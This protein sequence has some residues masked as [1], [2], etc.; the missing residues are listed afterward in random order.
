MGGGL[1]SL[2]AGNAIAGG[3]CVLRAARTRIEKY[4]ERERTIWKMCVA[5]VAA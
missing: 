5:A 1:V 3:L 4:Q 2:W